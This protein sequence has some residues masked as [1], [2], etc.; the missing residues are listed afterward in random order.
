M[1]SKS[2]LTEQRLNSLITGR[3]AARASLPLTLSASFQTV[4]GLSLALAAA[5][6]QVDALLMLNPSVS[7]GTPA[8]QYNGS[9]GL[10]LSHGRLVIAEYFATGNITGDWGA[11]AALP[12]ALTSAS[13][14]GAGLVDRFVT[15]S[16]VLQVSTPGTLNF[17]AK[18]SSGS[19]S[20]VQWGSFCKA[21]LL[22]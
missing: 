12:F 10:A 21:R 20:M 14:V 19:G 17:Q 16:G 18:L 5:E 9:G 11:D 13:V 7:G 6:Y 4:P 22:T 15:F 2:D 8:Y 3:Q 1:S